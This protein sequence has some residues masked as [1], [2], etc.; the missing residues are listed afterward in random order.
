M[1][2]ISGTAKGTPLRVPRGMRVR[3][4]G[5]R[6]RESLFSMLG[7]TVV[8][9]RVLDVF[10]G[11]GALGIEALSRG[12][13]WCGFVEKGRPAL[14]A[15]EEN[16]ARSGLGERAEVLRCDA[17]AVV[18]LLDAG[19]PVGLVLIDPPYAALHQRLDR[20]VAFLEELAQSAAVARDALIVLQHDSRTAIPDAVGP[21]RATDRRTYGTTALTFLEQPREEAQETDG[22]RSA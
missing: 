10:A 17:F 19:R 8:G 22:G 7:A 14:A 11:S 21:L 5:G 6:V 3:P 20:F 13:A 18:P 4:T 16:L 15:L 12:A 2:I 9:A 1:R